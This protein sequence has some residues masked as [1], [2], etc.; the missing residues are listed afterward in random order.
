MQQKQNNKNFNVTNDAVT[1]HVCL[2]NT[3]VFTLKL[4]TLEIFIF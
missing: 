2:M 3:K 1:Y 4:I